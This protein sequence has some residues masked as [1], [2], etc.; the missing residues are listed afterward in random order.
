MISL[1]VFGLV[2]WLGA[3][4]LDAMKKYR[5]D[6][7]SLYEPTWYVFLFLTCLIA[8]VLGIYGGYHNFYYRMASYYGVKNLGS[9]HDVDV[10]KMHGGQ[11]MDAGRVTFLPGSRL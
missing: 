9:Y 10:G 1:L 2:C 3:K 8:W 11:M 4:A 7:N 6:D 5:E